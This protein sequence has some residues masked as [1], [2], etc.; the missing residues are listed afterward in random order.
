[1]NERAAFAPEFAIAEP[2][3]ASTPGILTFGRLDDRDLVFSEARQAVYAL[4]DLAAPIW[5]DLESGMSG[6]QAMRRLIDAGTDP[7]QAASAV[8]D[9]VQGLR[10]LRQPTEP[11]PQPAPQATERLIG[12]TLSIAGVAVQLHL[13]RSLVGDV[14][15]AFGHLIADRHTTDY[16]F[17]AKASD[18]AVDVFSP[19][20]PDW[21]CRRSQ[22]VPLLKAQLIDAVLRSAQYEIAFHAAALEHHGKAVLLTGS[23]GAGKTTLAIA[24]A[25]AGLDMLGEDVALLDGGGLVTGVAMPFTAKASSWPLLSDRWPGITDHPSYC[26]PDGK[27]VCYIPHHLSP[28]QQPRPIGLVV[29]LNREEGAATSVETLDLGCA[30]EAL[31]AEGATRNNRLSASGFTALMDGLAGARCIRLT[32]SDLA[33]AA[34]AVLSAN[35]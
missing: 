31:I 17:C 25:Q 28:E 26:R 12:F 32:Y 30:L 8:A 9:A 23:P 11:R 33:E 20:Q 10:A 7:L 27:I 24:L 22:F 15:A 2:V 34:Q 21:S 16:L 29:L 35:A 1:M 14:V 13:S 19:G 6:P 4:S 5:Q 18:G 3:A